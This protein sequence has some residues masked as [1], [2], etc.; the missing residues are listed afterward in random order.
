M[1]RAPDLLIPTDD[2]IEFPVAR[3]RRHVAGILLQRVEPGFGTRA[4]HFAAATQLGNRA[5]QC[6]GRGLR[7]TQHPAGRGITGRKPDQHAILRHE[8][9]TGFGRGCLGGIHGPHQ[10][11]GHL[12]LTGAGA[13]HLGNTRNFR[14]DRGAGL[15]RI[16]ARGTDQAGGCPLSIIQHGLQQMLGRQALMVLAHGNCLCSLQKAAG[17]LGQLFDIH[18]VFQSQPG[19]LRRCVRNGKDNGTVKAELLCR[20]GIYSATP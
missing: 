16:A 15:D 6:G 4:V 5:G 3:E 17:P 14:I 11:G 2:G 12:R 10:V 9:V 18:R 7:G 20:S 8:A 1:D 13:L 19:E